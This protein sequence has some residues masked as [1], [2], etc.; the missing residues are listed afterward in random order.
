MIGVP[1]LSTNI[2]LLLLQLPPPGTKL[3]AGFQ[4]SQFPPLEKLLRGYMEEYYELS[5]EVCQSILQQEFNNKLV[6]KVQE[7]ATFH[8]K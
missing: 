4:W 7:M 5:I 1:L 8:G 6:L 2:Q 3:S